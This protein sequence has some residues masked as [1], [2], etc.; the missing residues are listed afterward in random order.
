MPSLF[1]LSLIAENYDL[2]N[3]KLA[4]VGDKFESFMNSWSSESRS[5]IYW[6]SSYLD[7]FKNQSKPYILSLNTV[8]DTM[9]FHSHVYQVRF[10]FAF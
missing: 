1:E 10:I 5:G 3:D 9:R 7:G 2:L 6:S 8:D 4:S